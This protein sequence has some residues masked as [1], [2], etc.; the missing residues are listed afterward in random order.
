MKKR[1]IAG[2]IAGIFIFNTNITLAHSHSHSDFD[3]DHAQFFQAVTVKNGTNLSMVECIALAFKNSPKI[4][5]KKYELDVASSNVGIARSKYFPEFNAGVGFFHENNSNSIYY[6]KYYRELPNVG[7]SLNKMIWDFGKTTAYVKMEEFYKIGAEYEFMDSLCATLFD[8]KDKYY[9]LLRAQALLQVAENN[10][11][12]NENFVKIS[13]KGADLTTA[14]VNLSKAKIELMEAHNNYLNARLDLSNSMYLGE[15]YDFTIKRTPTFNFNDDYEY[16]NSKQEP[17]EFVPFKFNFKRDDAIDIA[18]KSSPD[19]RVLEATKNAMEQSL[20]FIKRTYFPELSANVGYNFYNTNEA[21]NNNFN[22]GVNLTTGINLM[23]LKHSIKGADAQ[24]NLADNEINLF[25][26]DLYYEVK[27][28]FNNVDKSERTVPIAQ[29][30][31]KEALNNISVIEKKYIDGNLDYTSLQ[32]ARK[33]Y[34]DAVTNYVESLYNY[35]ISLIQVEM[36][37]HYHLV[38]IHHKTQHAILEH[39]D[40]L[41]EHLN[42]ALGCNEKELKKKKTKSNKKKS[43]SL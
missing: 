4:R 37:M 15:Q 36:A 42:E 33:D 1:V 21:S 2:L 41:I 13:R 27:R 19:L 22:V 34:I 6:N 5:R 10:V 3:D 43:E 38:D 16:K 32:D 20:L 40:E 28:A 17:A 11:D 18:Y 24:V 7:V 14:Q 8:I 31:V 30:S 12:I 26:K 23:E 29:S 25:K 9:K 35:N 39:S